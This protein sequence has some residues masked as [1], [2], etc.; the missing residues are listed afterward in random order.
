MK[1]LV[2]F[3]AIS[4]IIAGSIG[5]AN[6]QTFQSAVIDFPPN[7]LT[8]K[9]LDLG[10]ENNNDENI[11]KAIIAYNISFV[12]NS[13]IKATAKLSLT[14]SGNYKK[15]SVIQLQKL[16]SGSYVNVSGQ[17]STYTSTDSVFNHAVAF[18]ISAGN[19]YRSKFSITENSITTT[20]YSY[21]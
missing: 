8:Q 21:L 10:I 17:V 11:N 5:E 14:S 13:S 12:R 18:S 19:T 6:A 1:S 2:L 20:K 7:E 16:V 9:N 3:F 4:I 15:K